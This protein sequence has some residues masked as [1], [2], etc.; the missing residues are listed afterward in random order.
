MLNVLVVGE[1]TVDESLLVEE[2]GSKAG[3]GELLPGLVFFIVK[4][5]KEEPHPKHPEDGA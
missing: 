4:P 2:R 1:A 5:F 3:G